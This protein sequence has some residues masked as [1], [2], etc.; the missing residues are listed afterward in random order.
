M[1]G[2]IY[3][4]P[5]IQQGVEKGFINIDPFEPK[6]INPASID[7]RL[8]DEVAVYDGWVNTDV[9]DEWRRGGLGS[10]LFDGLGLC[11]NRLAVRDIKERIPTHSFKM[12]P[13]KGWVLHPDILYLMHTLE[14]IH[15]DHCVPVLDGKSS[16]GR[17]GIQVH[18]TAGFGDP[19]YDGQYTLEVTVK[20]AIRVYPGMRFCQMRFHSLEGE[21][22]N[23]QETGHYKGTDAEGAVASVAHTQ[24]QEGT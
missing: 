19:G 3:S 8:G 2:G 9:V 13:E 22:L 12:C 16:I 10:G 11:C 7:L 4:G 24:F 20:H 21:V 6:N 18:V 1:S 17:L 5:A 14:R 15:S 23:Y